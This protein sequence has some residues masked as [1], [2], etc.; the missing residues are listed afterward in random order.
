MTRSI[1]FKN[2][3][4]SMTTLDAKGYYAGYCYAECCN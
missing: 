2:I 1:T 3:T 4:L